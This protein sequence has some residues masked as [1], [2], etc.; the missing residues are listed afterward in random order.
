[1]DLWRIAW[2]TVLCASAATAIMLSGAYAYFMVSI[3]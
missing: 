2:F 3:S 1:M